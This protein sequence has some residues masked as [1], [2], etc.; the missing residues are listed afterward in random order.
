MV[1]TMVMVIMTPAVIVFCFIKTLDKARL[2]NR[3]GC[4]M[5]VPTYVT[6]FVNL[7]SDNGNQNRYLTRFTY[8]FLIKIMI[9][10]EK[11]ILFKVIGYY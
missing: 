7:M 4:I 10:F 1:V 5:N 2:W 6:P 9:F 3:Y 11:Q 8:L